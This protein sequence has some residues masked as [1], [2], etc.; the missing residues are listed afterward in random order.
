MREEFAA[1][2]RNAVRTCLNIGPA[3]RVFIIRDRPR[4]DI[5]EAIEEEATKAGASVRAWTIEDHSER[6]ITSCMT[7]GALPPPPSDCLRLLR[8]SLQR[9]GSCCRPLDA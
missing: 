8:Q 6:P 3:D 1:G 9:R 2:A 7:R 4:L 5:A